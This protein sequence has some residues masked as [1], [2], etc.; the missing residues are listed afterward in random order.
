MHKRCNLCCGTGFYIGAGLLTRNCENCSG[1]GK[2]Y[3][4]DDDIAALEKLR[5]TSSYEEAVDKIHA[6]NPEGSREE[7]VKI[8]EDEFDRI[9]EKPRKKKSK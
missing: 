4:E 6:L 8:F 1:S 5:Q 3:E 7:A 2:I 9:S